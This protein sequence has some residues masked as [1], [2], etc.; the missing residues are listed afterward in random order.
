[1]VL[2]TFTSRSSNTLLMERASVSIT[3]LFINNNEILLYFRDS[4]SQINKELW[5]LFNPFFSLLQEQGINALDVDRSKH[6]SHSELSLFYVLIVRS[7]QSDSNI[8]FTAKEL[9]KHID[10]ESC[11]LRDSD[12]NISLLVEDKCLRV[13]VNLIGI[14]KLIAVFLQS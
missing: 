13:E 5:S 11:I 7:R 14:T 10:S 3:E 6:S 1:M 2:H 8:I 12:L 9:I 4:L